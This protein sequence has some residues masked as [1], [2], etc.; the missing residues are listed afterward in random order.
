MAGH[1]EIER[2][3]EPGPAFALPDLT[4]VPGVAAAGEPVEHALAATYYDTADLRLARA[5]IT[6]RRRTGGTDAGWHLKLPAEAGAREE[7]HHPLGPRRAVPPK[8]VLEPV[9]GVVRA[10]PVTPVATLE[11]MR[12][13][14]P[15]L[16]DAGRVL[17]EEP[18]R[19]CFDPVLPGV[20]IGEKR[21][22]LTPQ[23]RES[24]AGVAESGREDGVQVVKRAEQV[25]HRHVAS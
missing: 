11:T 8:A 3:V 23:G 17:A 15:L 20:L 12:I 19:R 14:T 10:A 22:H 1:L 21:L 6:L 16:D 13:V 24:E 2:K 5:R 9:L 7:R 18:D 25:L 4:A